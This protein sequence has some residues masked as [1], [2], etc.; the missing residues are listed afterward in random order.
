MPTLILIGER[1]DWNFARDCRDMMARRKDFSAPMRLVVYPEAQHS[2][3]LR[4]PPR[5]HY[6]HRLEY[7]E[8]A[9]R[10][11]WRETTAALRHAFGR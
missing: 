6:G 3:N 1:D 9:D 11:A 8:A 4:L 5:S 10:D 7:D 2:F